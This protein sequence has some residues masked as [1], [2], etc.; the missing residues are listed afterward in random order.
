MTARYNKVAPIPQN[1][2]A[3]GAPDQDPRILLH[4][5]VAHEFATFAAAEQEARRL[6]ARAEEMG[7]PWRY[8]P[9]QR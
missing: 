3:W 8:W 1:V 7:V 6:N 5:Q 2:I 4:G 9:V